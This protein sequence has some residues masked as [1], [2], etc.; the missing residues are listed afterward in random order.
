MPIGVMW[1]RHEV[2]DRV[3]ILNIYVHEEFRR[4]KVATRL[5]EFLVGAYTTTSEVVTGFVN[6]L[7][8]PWC[9][10]CGFKQLSPHNW[11]LPID[12]EPKEVGDG[13]S[14]SAQ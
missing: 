10:A 7:S 6:E 3:A 5:L 1:Y 2:A 11:V 8:E 9:V 14:T 13:G 12:R 4:M